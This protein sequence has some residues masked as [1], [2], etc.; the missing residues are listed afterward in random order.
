M[1]GP[2]ENPDPNPSPINR[3]LHPLINQKGLEI[4]PPK[5]AKTTL[6]RIK[7]TLNYHSHNS[8]PDSHPRFAPPQSL[9]DPNPDIASSIFLLYLDFLS[10]YLTFLSLSN[11]LL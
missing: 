3:H 4:Y 2:K 11:L 6:P 7:I 8:N 1:M 10:L 5:C 9:R